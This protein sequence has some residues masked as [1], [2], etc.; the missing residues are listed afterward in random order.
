MPCRASLQRTLNRVRSYFL[1]RQDSIPVGRSRVLLTYRRL[2][3]LRLILISSMQTR[4]NHT[5]TVKKIMP[6]DVSNELSIE[7]ST[8]AYGMLMSLYHD[9]PQPG[10]PVIPLLYGAL[11]SNAVYIVPID[12]GFLHFSTE[13]K[14]SK[15]SSTSWMKILSVSRSTATT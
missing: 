2:L 11:R 7:D 4:S 1:H 12:L 6:R 13:F 3:H 10:C 8:E 14:H 5:G 15:S 9:M